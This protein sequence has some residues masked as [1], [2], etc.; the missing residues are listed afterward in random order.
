MVTSINPNDI[1]I[2]QW[3]D[4]EFII[5]E[6][7]QKDRYFASSLFNDSSFSSL[8]NYQELAGEVLKVSKVEEL[9]DKSNDYLVV[10][11][12]VKNYSFIY[13]KAFDGRIDN[14]APLDDLRKAKTRWVGKTIY[15][16]VWNI[17]TFDSNTEKIGTISS[18]MGEP[19]K[20]LDIV[21]GLQISGFAIRTGQDEYFNADSYPFWIIVKRN[22]GQQGFIPIM[23]S[24]TNCYKSNWYKQGY[25]DPR[26]LPFF[27]VD[28]RA[29]YRWGNEAW[30]LI[31]ERKVKIGW[32][33]EKVLMSWGKPEKINKLV[34]KAG[35]IQEQ[36][37]YDQYF[38]YF[39]NN[40]LT[41]IQDI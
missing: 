39:Q 5:L 36:W 9:N 23:Y 17:N 13:G 25:A 16:K 34:L 30:N 15:L 8:I 12:L 3:V 7:S 1:P 26:N 28:P 21:P 32:N 14:I 33:K 4:K 37:V 41:V 19:L 24:L 22:N 18:K 10:F 29:T 11:K 6:I 20:V 35:F 38:L 40:V 31:A 2:E 27:E